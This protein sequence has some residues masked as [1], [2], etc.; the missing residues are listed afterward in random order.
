MK[1]TMFKSRQTSAERK[2]LADAIAIRDTARAD[3]DA[4]QRAAG[5]WD[6]PARVAVRKAEAKL[7]AAPEAIEQARQAAAVYLV[8][9]A[10]DAGTPPATSIADARRDEQTAR[11]ELEAA[12]SALA[13]LQSKIGPA[14]TELR[15]KEGHVTTAIQALLRA[16][17]EVAAVLAEVE[18]LQAALWE[19]GAVLML[20]SRENGLD[21]ANVQT[22][23]LVSEFSPAKRALTRL[24]QLPVSWGFPPS[25]PTAAWSQAIAALRSDANAVLPDIATKFQG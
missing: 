25:A 8:E 17:P 4:V 18:R 23:P 9:Q 2:A 1:D 10:S 13:I 22:A 24:Q 7:A 3:L 21:E 19:S 5:S 14:E 16:S 20:L 15:W 6:A 11:D 12:K